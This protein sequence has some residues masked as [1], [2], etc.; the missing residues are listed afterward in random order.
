MNQTP[1][2]TLITGASSGL[3]AG[4]A[5]A[6][7]AKGYHLALCA[8][9]IDV[10]EA[11]KADLTKQFPASII[12][13]Y[14]LDVTDFDAV[15]NVIAM[16]SRDFGHLSRVIVNAGIGQGQRI[17]TGQSKHNR[18]TLDTNLTAALAQCE[19]AMEQFRSQGFGH[20]VLISSV[21]ALRGMGG[22]M[23]I[24]AASKAGLAN[25]AEGIRADTLHE[26]SIHVSTIM[27]GYILTPIN[28]HVKNAPFR[29][30]LDRGAQL[31]VETIERQP[32]VAYVPRW[33]W[34]ILAPII[35]RLPLSWWARLS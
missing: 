32:N 29:I 10:L 14:P 6:F 28:E 11:L 8:R 16:A 22:S 17:G 15:F 20:L 25:L 26:P 34:A 24:Y 3:G 7:A 30:P 35:K 4:M 33:P 27:P 21:S 18:K 13:V 5:R 2:T 31:L 9:R 19:A 23:A 1:F 12:K